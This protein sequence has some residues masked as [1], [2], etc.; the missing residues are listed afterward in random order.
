MHIIFVQGCGF[1][2]EGYIFIEDLEKFGDKV[3]DSHLI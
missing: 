1:T 3:L 2:I